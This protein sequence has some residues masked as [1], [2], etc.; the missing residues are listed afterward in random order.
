M[1]SAS[2]LFGHRR[3]EPQVSTDGWAPARCRY[4]RLNHYFQGRV[5]L[6]G[7]HNTGPVSP[8]IQ[9]PAGANDCQHCRKALEKAGLK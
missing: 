5:S 7:L 1:I 2:A 3:R 6:C 8:T 9:R 4:S